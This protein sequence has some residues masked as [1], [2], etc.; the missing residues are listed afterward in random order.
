[1]KYI[2][3]LVLL[4]GSSFIV[5]CGGGSGDTVAEA[6]V[7]TTPDVPQNT[8]MRVACVGD[9]ITQG[10]G[11]RNE[12][13]NSYPA[14][15]KRMLGEGWDVKNFGKSGATLMKQGNRS[16]WDTTQFVS[17]HE[18][19]PD[20]VVIML[21]TNDAKSSNWGNNEPFISDYTAVIESYKALLSQPEIYICYPP[22]SY[23]NFAG[24][25][26][27]R[28]KN[29]LIP[30]ISQVASANNVSVIDI[31]SAL[32]NKASL[33]PDTLHPNEEG[34]KQIAEAVYQRVY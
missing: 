21:G 32:K 19:N 2:K 5:G 8:V 30:K 10:V 29:E 4:I 31:H 12:A 1:M 14:Q 15:L 17:S 20:I 34:A 7:S 24:I 27:A 3:F 13:I 11:V 16:Y 9:S 6:P 22:P 33:F 26:D 23:G 25:T 28:I 18:Y